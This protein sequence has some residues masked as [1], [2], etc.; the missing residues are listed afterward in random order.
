MRNQ[1]DLKKVLEKAP[2]TLLN[3]PFSLFFYSK[4]D[5]FP[6]Y[7]FAKIISK[8][9][10]IEF[11]NININKSN[12]ESNLNSFF[13][14]SFFQKEKLYFITG[15][16]DLGAKLQKKF[17]AQLS[18]SC[19][20]T[21]F[22]FINKYKNIKSVKDNFFTISLFDI[23]AWFKRKLIQ[24]KM[25]KFGVSC[26]KDLM[27]TILSQIYDK[28]LHMIELQL[29]KLALYLIDKNH[30]DIVYNDLISEALSGKEREYMDVL[31][32]MFRD[33]LCRNS[34][35]LVSGYEKLKQNME[36]PVIV[37]S[38]LKKL[39]VM[40][41][42]YFFYNE[43]NKFKNF[44]ML[45]KNKGRVDYKKFMDELSKIKKEISTSLSYEPKMNFLNDIRHPDALKQY[46][47]LVDVVEKDF[48]C[49][50]VRNFIM[51][52]CMLK[53][54]EILSYDDLFLLITGEVKNY[55]NS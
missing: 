31:N 14:L 8:N 21:F 19:S 49:D 52:N 13:E 26:S 51:K 24:D 39:K 10:N 11:I 22:I 42:F 5:V 40:K 43:N 29:E 17:I 27:E 33:V 36:P 28:D 34:Q 47:D 45:F 15:F 48:L 18:E 25:E 20:N 37:F 1:L 4:E 55:G 46:L 35:E 9:K 7:Y 38:I 12:F 50:I 3:K 2:K 54:G 30:S 16:E 44:C 41:D 6:A 32:K 53:M 23:P